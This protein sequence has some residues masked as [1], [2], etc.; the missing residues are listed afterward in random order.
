MS[1]PIFTVVR[2]QIVVP[3][4]EKT[5]TF[6]RSD[7]TLTSLITLSTTATCFTYP[8]GETPLGLT[9]KTVS[10]S[11]P[12]RLPI[13]EKPVS[14]RFEDMKHPTSTTTPTR[15]GEE[16]SFLVLRGRSIVTVGRRTK[17]RSQ[18]IQNRQS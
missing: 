6:E 10:M 13:S 1:Q 11:F 14:R 8:A 16:M 7:T 4:V 5:R 3:E 18:I 2:S 9:I 12:I 15:T 17:Q